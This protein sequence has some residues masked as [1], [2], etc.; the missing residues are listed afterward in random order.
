MRQS[1]C[2]IAIATSSIIDQIL[3]HLINQLSKVSAWTPPDAPDPGAFHFRFRYQIATHVL[4][5]LQIAAMWSRII[6]FSVDMAILMLGS[7]T[8]GTIFERLLNRVG[9]YI[10]TKRQWL[11]SMINW[12]FYGMEIQFEATMERITNEDAQE[13]CVY[14]CVCVCVCVSVCGGY[15]GAG[16]TCGRRWK[17][18]LGRKL[19]S[20][21]SV[22]TF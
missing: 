18:P 1:K 10:L 16:E 21:E 19:F 20:K 7:D 8:I 15:S 4:R 3:I 17:F 13:L 22:S 9:P 12:I 11:Y 14:V 6:N 5:V 2:K